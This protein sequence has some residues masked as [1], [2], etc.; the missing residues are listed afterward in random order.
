MF[1]RVA[2][3]YDAV[4]SVLSLGLD[5]RWRRRTVA[6]LR[7]A[8]GA[9]V[10][11]VATGTGA[12]AAE[13]HRATGGSVSITACDLNE[14]MLGVARRRSQARNA[15]I[16]FVTCD[17]TCLPFAAESF[18]AVTIGFAIDD[19]PDRERCAG[20]MWRVLR[21]NGQ[22]A[23]LELGQPDAPLLRT[24]YRL[25]LKLFRLLRHA[26]LDG[27]GHLE[28]EIVTYRGPRAVE[29]LLANAGFE[30][31]RQHSLAGG[32][33]RLHLAEKPVTPSPRNAA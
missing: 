17:A 6:A 27:Y 32:I 2:P 21:P 16:T 5:R 22:L 14:S 31:Y 33:A 15:G 7:L 19:M 4:N 30:R 10:L 11:D 3:Y 12:L 9:D 23:L 25:Y 26:R 8:P 1:H 20:E 18:D 24:L 13:I 28:Q 29:R